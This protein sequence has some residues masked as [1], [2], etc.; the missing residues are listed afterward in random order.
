MYFGRITTYN[1]NRLPKRTDNQAFD[2]NSNSKGEDRSSISEEDGEQSSDEKEPSA[3]TS[4]QRNPPGYEFS[5]ATLLS[6]IFVG[7][8]AAFVGI[9]IA[10]KA[11]DF[12]VSAIYLSPP[13]VC[14]EEPLTQPAVPAGSQ[15][16][17]DKP[18]QEPDTSTKPAKL[19]KKTKDQNNQAPSEASSCST[20]QIKTQQTEIAKFAHQNFET[21]LYLI[22]LSLLS[23]FAGI[24]LI[25]N[26]SNQMFKQ[27]FK[28]LNEQVKKNSV[29]IEK[30]K[31]EHAKTVRKHIKDREKF[32]KDQQRLADEQK[33][34]QEDQAEY[35]NI[36]KATHAELK[37]TQADIYRLQENHKN[38]IKSCH[39]A[40]KLN[41][42]AAYYGHLALAESYYPN[43]AAGWEQAINTLDKGIEKIRRGDTIDLDDEYSM[44]LNRACF[45]NLFTKDDPAAFQKAEHDIFVDLKKCLELDP[46]AMEEDFKLEVLGISKEI[47]FEDAKNN[48][49]REIKGDLV[50]LKDKLLSMPEFEKF[51]S[52]G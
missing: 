16:V 30:E 18:L 20:E 34:L 48:D 6:D 42:K 3:N 50:N 11:F 23:G 1:K 14:Q 32:L 49:D 10:T 13:A 36:T 46:K 29:D 28:D 44:Y 40:I 51:K 9:A 12:N 25:E 8:V 37:V 43:G 17:T 5:F 39:D 22:A 35:T 24:R 2:S 19:D 33:K 26:I 15:K 38:A 21:W 27:A 7:A 52:L 31:K 4:S 45:R 41:P 47:V